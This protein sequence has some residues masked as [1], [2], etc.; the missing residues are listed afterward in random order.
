MFSLFGS[1]DE[2]KRSNPLG[3]PKQLMSMIPLLALPMIMMHH[4]SEETNPMM[5]P[6][7]M[8]IGLLVFTS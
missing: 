6:M 8:L 2:K 7:M 1:D 3:F 5:M 4:D